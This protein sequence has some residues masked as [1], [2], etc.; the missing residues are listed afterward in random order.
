MEQNHRNQLREAT[1]KAKKDAMEEMKI[2]KDE[3]QHN[4]YCRF[5]RFP[6]I[7]LRM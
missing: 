5:H 6:F 1:R 2:E 4:G 3:V 7:V